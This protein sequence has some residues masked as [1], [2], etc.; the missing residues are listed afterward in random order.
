[1]SKV[2]GY[3]VFDFETGG[4]DCQKHA[5][6]EIGL[7]FLDGITLQEVGRF[8]TYIKP[9]IKEYTQEAL[10]FTGL[11]LE[12]LSTKGEDIKVV[13]QRLQD[14]LKEMRAKTGTTS[15]TKK[16]TLVGHNVIFD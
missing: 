5:A 4:F 8:E 16:P 10:T 14:W 7:I 11:S 3:L 15:Y 1:M 13:G 9:Y 6:T 2:G 12:L